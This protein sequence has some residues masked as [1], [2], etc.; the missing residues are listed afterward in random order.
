M[1]DLIVDKDI[2]KAEGLPARAFTDPAILDLELETIFKSNWL[3][4]PESSGEDAD[5]KSV[6]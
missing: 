5:R 6:V 4:V 1:K 3:L 2:A